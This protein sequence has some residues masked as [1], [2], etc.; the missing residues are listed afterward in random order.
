MIFILGLPPA[1]HTPVWR[2]Y[3]SQPF[4]PRGS[5]LA[6]IRFAAAFSHTALALGRALLLFSTFAEPA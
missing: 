2:G 1:L 5:S 3:F 6:A 4:F